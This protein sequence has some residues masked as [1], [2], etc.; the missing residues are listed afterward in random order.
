MDADGFAGVVGERVRNARTMRG[1]S[2][3]ALAA[4]AGI[5]KG[6]LSE[7]ENGIR[8]PTLSTL[9]ALAGALEVPLATLLA[10]QAGAVVESPGIAAQL[11]DV[12][13]DASGTVETYRLELAAGAR[14][15]SV[16][17]GARVTET[18]VVTRGAV[19]AGRAGEERQAS[20]GEVLTWVSDGPHAY[21]SVDGAA[22]AVLVVTTPAV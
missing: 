15:Q 20:A 19:R 22:A 4:A 11:L 2:L 16:G 5:G 6:S 12:V 9:Y 13:A 7:V 18:L 3:S 21:R 1:L 8:N 10:D 14:H 17:H